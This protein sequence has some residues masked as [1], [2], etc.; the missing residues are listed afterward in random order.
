MT[1]IYTRLGVRPIVNARGMNTMASGSLMPKPVLD[2]M[3]EAATAFVDMAELNARAG[4]HIARLIGVE[5]AHVTSGSAGGLL[6]AAAACMAGTDPERIRRLPDTSGMPNE[7]VIQR[8]QRIQYDQALRTAG[9]RLVEVGSAEACTP[10]EVE[11]AIGDRTAALVFIVSPRLGG[12]GVSDERMAEIAHAHGRPLIVDAASTLPPVAH[13][14]RWTA[15]GADLVIYS[16]G[17]GIRGPQ[18][19]GLLL[20]RAELIRAAAV[21]GAPNAAIGRP[22]KVS[23]ED[24]VGLVTALELFLHEDHRAEWDQHLAEARL[25]A[26]AAAGLPGV[27]VRLE[28]DWSVW[29]A[30]TVLV[31]LDRGLTGLTPEAVM[32]ALRRGEPPIMVRVFQDALLL[33]PHCLR[34]DEAAIAARRLREELAPRA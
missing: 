23:K 3:A 14:T 30:P 24:I 4:E 32:E 10:S 31:E 18:G 29:T 9:A 7:L 21:N 1:D 12:R 20:G 27:R 17:K 8:C 13:L 2:A 33:D 26:E 5:A 34:E 16:G 28:D 11:A 6:L 22:C 15:L 25:I 19:S